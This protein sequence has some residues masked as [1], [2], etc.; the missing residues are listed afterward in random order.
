MKNE[1]LL[2]NGSDFKKDIMSSDH[3]LIMSFYDDFQKD[4][5]DSDSKID[6]NGNT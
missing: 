4:N 5:K 2:K 1:D 3:K 6:K